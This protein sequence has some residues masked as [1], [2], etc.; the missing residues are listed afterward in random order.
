MRKQVFLL[1]LVIVA[2]ISC[3]SA[4]KFSDVTGKEWKL[5]EVN[6]NG[7]NI[8]F[9]RDTLADEEAGDIFTLN[10]DAQNISV[11][12]APNQGSSRYTLGSNQAISLAPMNPTEAAPLRQPEK[13]REQDFFVYMQKV[14]KWNLVDTSLELYS[15][16]EDDSEVKLV[17]SL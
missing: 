3:S 2:T 17:F 16:T 12:G 7:R 14:Y 11:T 4:P 8:Q 10:F 6:T 5:I 13:L 1:M 15:K 9:N